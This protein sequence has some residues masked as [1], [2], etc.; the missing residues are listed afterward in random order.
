MKVT[1]LT[2]ATPNFAGPAKN[3]VDSAIA[4]GFDDAV[5]LGPQDIAETDFR[6]RNAALLEAPRGA[7]YWLWK[8]YLVLQAVR[9]L[10]RGEC[11]LYSDAGR[12]NYY[13]FSSRPRRLIDKMEAAG[14]GY[15]IGSPVPHLGL[16]GEWTKRDCLDIMGATAEA[17]RRV[18]LLMTWSLW[19]NSP[20]S[21]DFLET[22]LSYCCDPRCLSD[23]P[24]VLG[25]PD[26]PGFKAH[27]YDQSILSILAHQRGSPTVN[28]TGSL[29]QRIIELA[30]NSELGHT[31][32]KRP[33]NAEDMLAGMGPSILIREFHRLRRMRP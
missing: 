19:T 26:L 5:L 18:P 15:L 20:E 29:V 12:T 17:V 24:N 33:Q 22:W 21:I 2:Y 13:S 9:R 16:V 27:R 10:G 23:A 28:M 30:P 4:S 3:L 25:N 11:V 6:R 14:R 8:P 31:F 1:L 7:G 32:Y